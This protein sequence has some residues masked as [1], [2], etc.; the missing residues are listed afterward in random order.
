MD[1]FKLV[2]LFSLELLDQMIFL[3]VEGPPHCFSQWLPVSTF[4]PTVHECSF[5]FTSSPTLAISYL[6]DPSHSE[7]GEVI[8]HGGFHLPFPDDKKC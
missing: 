2:F 1:L 5:S 6:F 4:P 8:D 7:K 3:T